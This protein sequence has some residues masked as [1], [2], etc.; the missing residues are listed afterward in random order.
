MAEAS[1]RARIAADGQQFLTTL[2]NLQAATTAWAQRNTQVVA[3][4]STKMSTVS[5]AAGAKFKAS[6]A[7]NALLD[8]S[9]AVEDAQYG[10]QGVLNNL[11]GIATALGA[12][13]GLTGVI[14]I[15]AVA[16]YQLTKNFVS[17]ITNAKAVKEATDEV[18][19]LNK[20]LQETNA[21]RAKESVEGTTK[22]TTAMKDA[23]AAMNAEVRESNIELEH[24]L[25]VADKMADLQPTVTFGN[26][27]EEALSNAEAQIK[28]TEQIEIRT[29][30]L[31]ALDEKSQEIAK[32]ESEAAAVSEK[33]QQGAKA[34]DEEAAARLDAELK[35]KEAQQRITT[36]M[37]RDQAAAPEDIE[38]VQRARQLGPAETPEE[39]KRRRDDATRAANQARAAV[40]DA[41]RARAT[42]EEEMN[43]VEKENARDRDTL[44]MLEAQRIAKL[45]EQ[46]S[47]GAK[48]SAQANEEAFMR[49]MEEANIIQA[50]QEKE[51]AI[52]DKQL[53][54]LAKLQEAYDDNTA[55]LAKTTREHQKA[56]GIL[57]KEARIKGLREHGRDTQAD[58]E[59][60]A[61][62]IESRAQEIMATGQRTPEQAFQLATQLEGGRGRVDARPRRHRQAGG[63]EGITEA[64]HRSSSSDQRRVERH[65][66]RMEKHLSGKRDDKGDPVKREH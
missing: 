48:L 6:G 31:S 7:Q 62:R 32:R 9:R 54:K 42:V 18:D 60:R 21:L 12:G 20:K 44:Q 35:A 26:F 64:P 33:L 47:E 22:A 58:R 49:E 1:I 17:F 15:A 4:Q 51:D 37:Q 55:A 34:R 52:L 28:L 41:G 46:K 45:N 13:A 2:A 30:A 25:Q 24:R 59:E 38:A 66:E 16:V 43:R 56:L 23:T 11:P 5:A 50:N 19:R 10:L 27:R 53:K 29:G 36:A 39:T 61:L 65:L 63:I 3:A 40:V 57:E 14:S 8:L